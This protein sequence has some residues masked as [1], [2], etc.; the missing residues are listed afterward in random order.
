MSQDWV[1]DMRNQ[2]AKFGVNDWVETYK[3]DE[4]MLKEFLTHKVKFIGEEFDE[5]KLA[6]DNI[7]TGDNPA[8]FVDAAVDMI[9]VILDMMVA[10]KVDMN[11]AWDEVH[12]TV[13]SKEAGIKPERPNPLGIPDLIKPEGWE[14]PEHGHNTG[15]IGCI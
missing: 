14:G 2:H 3:Y 13:M 6:L 8:D 15:L 11:E 5:M 4:A 1:Q 7:E 9:T 10:M 12:R